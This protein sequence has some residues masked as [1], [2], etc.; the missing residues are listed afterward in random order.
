[1]SQPS[2]Y[3]TKWLEEVGHNP[4]SLK[5]AKLFRDGPEVAEVTKS[6][7]RKLGFTID[8]TYG[9]YVLFVSK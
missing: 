6:V 3:C 1:L 7:S 8:L 2:V 4:D 5:E 9:M